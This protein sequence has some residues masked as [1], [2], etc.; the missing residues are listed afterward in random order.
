M[1]SGGIL[2]L[3][4]LSV[5]GVLGVLSSDLENGQAV[6][7]SWFIPVRFVTTIYAPTYLMHLRVFQTEIRDT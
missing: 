7:P 6:D 4:K 5:Q 1:E 2:V 3:G